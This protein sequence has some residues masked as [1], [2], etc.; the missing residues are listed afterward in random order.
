MKGKLERGNRYSMYVCKITDEEESRKSWDE[1]EGGGRKRMKGGGARFVD[2]RT[3]RR[4]SASLAAKATPW[5]DC[6]EEDLLHS[7]KLKLFGAPISRH[8]RAI[9]AVVGPGKSQYFPSLSA[10][11]LSLVPIPLFLHSFFIHEAVSVCVAMVG[12]PAA[13]RACAMADGR[14]GVCIQ[15]VMGR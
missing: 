12:D 3:A 5:R 1:E 11:F 2:R 14:L 6:S 8:C 13:V 7:S 9:E 15:N 10:S 4:K